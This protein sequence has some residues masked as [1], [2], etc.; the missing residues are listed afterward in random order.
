MMAPADLRASLSRLERW[1][2]ER[3]FKG[4][5]PHDALRSRIV[6]TLTFHNRLLGIAW[7]QFLRRSP[8]NFRRILQVEPGHNPKGM[9]L[10]LAGYLR[11]YKVTG[12]NSDRAQI[13]YF[14]DW[15]RNSQSSGYSGA[16]WGY[17]FDWPNRSFFAPAGTPTVVNTSFVAHAFLDLYE[18]FA[19][20]E[21][22]DLA[23]SACEF[24]MR[25]LPRAIEPLGFCFSY[26][27]IDRRRVHN[28]NMLAASL[29]ARVAAVTDD[30]EYRDAARR[31]VI[32][33]VSRQNADGSW[34]YGVGGSESW[35][36][37]FHTGF[38]LVS[39]LHYIRYTGEREFEGALQ[40]GYQFWKSEL[41]TAG[42]I[43]KFYRQQL[44]PIDVHCV[45]QGVLTLLAFAD[46]DKTA[47]E[48]GLQLARWAAANLQDPKG[49]FHYQIGRYCRNRIP[50][51]RWGQA[52]MFRA[53]VECCALQIRQ[54]S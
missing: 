16:C 31:A 26:T 43:P 36:D 3:N 13:Q 2:I 49:Y 8:L 45:A 40:A 23:R 54:R 38:V 19:R 27:P 50:Y 52:W 51:I 47:V 5:D 46:R 24:I 17:N 6:R 33:T 34:P 41:F 14:A 15:L 44:Y 53:L 28:A 25:D 21:D 18:A 39:L 7:V 32:F 48:R 12:D 29:L 9:G 20:A 1:L 10:F 35:V 42:G 11:R 37:N 30:E 22:L 4:F